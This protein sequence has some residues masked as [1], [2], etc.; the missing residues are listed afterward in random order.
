[1]GKEIKYF[2]KQFGKYIESV[3]LPSYP[4]IVDYKIEEWFPND[5]EYKFE[6]YFYY[7]SYPDDHHI[8]ILIEDSVR[9]MITS[10]SIEEIVYGINIKIK[11]QFMGSATKKPRPMKSRKSGLKTKKRIDSNHL[12]IKKLKSQNNQ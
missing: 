8:D 12:V 7:D 10:F 3:I 2:K 9:E 4:Q 1:M 6:F 11:K 5:T